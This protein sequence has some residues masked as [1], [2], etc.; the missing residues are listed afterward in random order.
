[1]KRLILPLLMA[2]SIAAHAE[3]QPDWSGSYYCKVT[4]SGGVKL[5][6]ETGRWESVRFSVAD[7]AILITAKASGIIDDKLMGPVSTYQITVKD[8]GEEGEGNVCVDRSRPMGERLYVPVYR[9]GSTGCDQ[10]SSVYKINFKNLRI[11]V[12]FP[13][14]YMDETGQN[15]DTPNVSVGKCDKVS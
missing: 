3:E 1:M 11:L 8:F 14:G 5:E 6:P 9:D 4:A 13:G 2:S 7:D 12:M 15:T 10:Y